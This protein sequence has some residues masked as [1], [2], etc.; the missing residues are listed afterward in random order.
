MEHFLSFEEAGAVLGCSPHTLRVWARQGLISHARLGRRIVFSPEDL[1]GFV[2]S[3]RVKAKTKEP[4]S[5]T[6]S[7][8]QQDRSPFVTNQ[9]NS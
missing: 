5:A 7:S 8:R 3:R 1:E 4:P 9:P 2:N 6:E